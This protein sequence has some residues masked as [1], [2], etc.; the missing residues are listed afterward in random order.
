MSEDRRCSVCGGPLSTRN[1]SGICAKNYG[2]RVQQQLRRQGRKRN[3]P[4]KGTPPWLLPPAYEID[5]DGNQVLDKNGQPVEIVDEV[6]I[7]VAV[8]GVRR[9]A[10][11]EQERKEVII[12]MI[13][14]GWQY[15]EIADH[16]GTSPAKLRPMIEALG[17]Q[18]I[19][20]RD[21]GRSHPTEAT[22][23]RKVQG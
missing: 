15:R 5:D 16:I 4:K 13:K 10:L 23:I 1:Q 8:S 12:K 14:T 6:A 22:E 17:Y 11:T 7:R 19:P 21:P 9:V 18:I 2:C 20:R 3:G